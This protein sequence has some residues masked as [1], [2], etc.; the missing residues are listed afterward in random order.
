MA[1][2][3]AGAVVV[4]VV[5]RPRLHGREIAY[6]V[7]LGVLAMLG[8]LLEWTVSAGTLGTALIQLPLVAVA[9]LAAVAISGRVGWTQA[10]I[11]SITFLQQGAR[12]AL[13]NFGLGFVLAAPWALGNIATGPFE[14]D[15]FA[16][17]WQVL[18]ALR[19]GIAEE[20]WIRVFGITL[21]YWAFRRYTRARPALLAAALLGTYWFAFLHAPG[22][23]VAALL[24]GTIQL[25]PMT[26]VWLR[27]GL[28][29]AIG[30]H[31]CVD[32]VRFLAAYLAVSGIW[33]Q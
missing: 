33:F 32:L 27:R 22:N 18:A 15:H 19:P 30:F 11:G 13:R 26:F 12:P 8:G 25:L 10:D 31:V 16:A 29:M 14:E 2:I 17:G 5:L 7:V 24:L 4:L 3:G 23:P 6:A 28:E 20:V 1:P 9:L 21:L